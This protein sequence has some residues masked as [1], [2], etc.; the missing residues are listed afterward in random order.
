[1]VLWWAHWPQ[2]HHNP[3]PDDRV[4]N[5]YYG[6][7]GPGYA[8]TLLI[9]SGP[10]VLVSAL[11]TRL[12]SHSMRTSAEDH[13]MEYHGVK[14]RTLWGPGWVSLPRTH[15]STS[16]KPVAVAVVV[17]GEKE[18]L[19]CLHCGGR[20][21]DWGSAEHWTPAS[22]LNTASFSAGISSDIAVNHLQFFRW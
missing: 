13:V 6:C 10:V 4:T 8:V 21:H 12:S 15:Q 18:V 1:M 20:D 19:M 3:W 17:G 5:Q 7:P 11:M 2:C 16:D 22:C 9:P 14:T